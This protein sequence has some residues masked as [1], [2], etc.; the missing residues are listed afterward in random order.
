MSKSFG[1]LLTELRELKGYSMNQLADKAGI[2]VSHVSRMEGEKRGTPKLGTIKKLA[3]VLGHY[4][5]LMLAAGWPKPESPYEK[6]NEEARQ[7]FRDAVKDDPDLAE[8]WQETESREE[9]KL[10]FKQAKKLSPEAIREVI[11]YMRFVEMEEG[12]E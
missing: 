8:F 10:L 5:E 12:K 2:D 3:K 1:E 9:L 7:V 4:D 6:N 11:K